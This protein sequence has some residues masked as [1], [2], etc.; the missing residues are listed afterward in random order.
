MLMNR[1]LIIIHLQIGLMR[2]GI[3][4]AEGAP[5]DIL[6]K[7]EVDSLEDA[8]LQLCVKHG[9]SD[10]ADD[11][12]KQIET[13]TSRNE[14]IEDKKDINE[15][16]PPVVKRKNS[17]ESNDSATACCGGVGDMDCNKKSFVKGLQ[18]TTKRRMKALLAKNFLQVSY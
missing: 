11:N 16:Q 2:N 12:L 18:I 4:L 8:F 13:H 10:E 3:L 1:K 9:V 14:S 6:S 17:I 5:Q 7:C 15:K